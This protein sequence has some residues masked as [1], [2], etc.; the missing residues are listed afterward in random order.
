MNMPNFI[1][2][3]TLDELK[4][5]YY[6]KIISEKVHNNEY[7]KK[8]IMEDPTKEINENQNELTNTKEN[9]KVRRLVPPKDNNN[10]HGF[11][12]IQFIIL[13]LIISLIT[14]ISIGYL[15]IK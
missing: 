2:G 9:S 11:N 15:I 5:A 1:H 7:D 4:K 3:I 10:S 13:T 8:N 14:G 6:S 12:S